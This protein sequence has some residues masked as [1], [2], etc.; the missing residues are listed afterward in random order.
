MFFRF[1]QI[2]DEASAVE[3]SL[4]RNEA[5][6]AKVCSLVVQ[7]KQAAKMADQ[8]HQ[9]QVQLLEAKVEELKLDVYLANR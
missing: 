4:V 3:A 8:K 1:T 7:R 5:A 9:N 2:P 6:E